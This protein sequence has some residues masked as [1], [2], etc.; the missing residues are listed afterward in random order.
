M[1]SLPISNSEEIPESLVQMP[2]IW[3]L[4]EISHFHRSPSTGQLQLLMRAGP[5][6]PVPLKAWIFAS[7]YI[8]S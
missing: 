2:N 1:D 5:P 6:V 8:F 3:H 4:L 7:I